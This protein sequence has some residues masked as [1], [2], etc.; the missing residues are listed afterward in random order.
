MGFFNMITGNITEE[1]K[2]SLWHTNVKQAVLK[3]VNRPNMT[4]FPPYSSSFFQIKGNEIIVTA[5]ADIGNIFGG[6]ERQDFRI[7]LDLGNFKVKKSEFLCRGLI[8]NKD[9]WKNYGK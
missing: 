5:Y 4:Q 6:V 8:T 1:Q 2:V 9:K 7:T 3:K